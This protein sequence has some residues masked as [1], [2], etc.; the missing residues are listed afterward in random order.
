MSATPT[1]ELAG[2]IAGLKY[3]DIPAQ[4]R[5]RVKDYILDAL[6]SALA[7]RHGDEVRQIQ[8]LAA[9]LGS[10]REASVIGGERLSLAGAT[11]LNGYLVTAVTVCDVHR[12]TL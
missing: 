10:S 1:T 6:A 3:D 2:F 5:E 11:L 12:P 8:A 4:V 7:G 9:A